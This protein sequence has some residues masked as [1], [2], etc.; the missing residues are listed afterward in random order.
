[1]EDSKNGIIILMT[2]A[3]WLPRHRCSHTVTE[4]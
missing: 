2:I 4:V 3:I 1:M